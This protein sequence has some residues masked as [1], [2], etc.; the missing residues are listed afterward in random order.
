MASFESFL[1]DLPRFTF[2]FST[3][4][5]DLANTSDYWQSIGVIAAFGVVA[6]LMCV[7][8]EVLR[9]LCSGCCAKDEDGDD[10]A[11]PLVGENAEGKAGCCGKRCYFGTMLVT[12]VGTAGGV[13]LSFVGSLEVTSTMSAVSTA[14]GNV[15][16]LM[17]SAADTSSTLID[18]GTDLAAAASGLN[19]LAECAALPECLALAGQLAAL[20]T[21]FEPTGGAGA[22]L[23]GIV[24]LLEVPAQYANDAPSTSDTIDG[25]RAAAV[26]GFGAVT[27]FACAGAV[28]RGCLQSGRAKAEPNSCMQ[29]LCTC[30]FAPLCWA[31]L[32]LCWVAAS[33]HLA[34]A[35]VLAD[36]CVDTNGVTALLPAD[37]AE[38][39]SYFLFC[40]GTSPFTAE[41]DAAEAALEPA[42]ENL[43]AIV[44]AANA[45]LPGGPAFADQIEVLV[46]TLATQLG[47]LTPLVD[48]LEP[49]PGGAVIPESWAAITTAICE[50]APDDALATPDG[51]TI[52]AI[53]FAVSALLVYATQWISTGCAPGRTASLNDPSSGFH[54][55]NDYDSPFGPE[56]GGSYGG[57]RN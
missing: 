49:A 29:S 5:N 32:I 55:G 54:S 9:C 45:A 14:L 35:T 15:G 53:G 8:L 41:L 25:L 11:S 33:G 10:L 3:V 26:Y 19:S 48:C 23:A 56:S 51:L 52:A 34:I 2:G 1:R 43:D 40:E 17:T 7:L 27:V 18:T 47:Q 12:L 20:A 22:A 31:T 39:F 36:F 24:T 28:F 57:N 46:P 4:S 44:A 50:S 13:V 16:T 6:A 37:N 30:I 21:E 42:V 38:T